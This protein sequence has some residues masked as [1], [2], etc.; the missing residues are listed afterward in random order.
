MS[1]DF[2]VYKWRRDHLVE[3]ENEV[4]GEF[5][6]ERSTQSKSMYV[7]KFDKEGNVIKEKG[8][9]E[10]KQYDGYFRIKTKGGYL[11]D[12]EVSSNMF[13][14]DAKK[15][16]EGEDYTFVGVSNVDFDDDGG[17]INMYH[18]FYYLKPKSA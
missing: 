2:N 12:S 8:N 3:N 4:K 11:G 9:Y 17:K 18:D 10:T 15:K 7:P 1:K 16:I 14:A 6:D 13:G 5:R